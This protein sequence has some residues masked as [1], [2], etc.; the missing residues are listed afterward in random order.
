MRSIVLVFLASV[1]LVLG[2]QAQQESINLFN[3]VNLDAWEY[4]LVDPD[5][6]LENV[7]SVENEPGEWNTYEIHFRT[8]R[9]L[10]I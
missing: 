4:F 10:T 1:L 2:T 6:K 7:W 3:G 8:V 9:I 5:L